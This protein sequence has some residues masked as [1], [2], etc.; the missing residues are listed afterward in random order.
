MHSVCDILMQ[1]KPHLSTFLPDFPLN[2]LFI[3]NLKVRESNYFSAQ[4]VDLLRTSFCKF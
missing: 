4:A 3:E 1:K 2:Y